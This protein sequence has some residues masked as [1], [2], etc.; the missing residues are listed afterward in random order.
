MAVADLGEQ[1][2]P[3]LVAC[4]FSQSTHTAPLKI[5]L[6]PGKLCYGYGTPAVLNRGRTR[7]WL[8]FACA[9]L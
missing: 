4:G 3:E 2:T 1:T 9:R 6:K 7:V 5:C 8:F